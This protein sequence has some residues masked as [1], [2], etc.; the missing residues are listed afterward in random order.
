[1]NWLLELEVKRMP[2]L[3]VEIPAEPDIVELL[4]K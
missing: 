3:E 1:M 2:V 4:V